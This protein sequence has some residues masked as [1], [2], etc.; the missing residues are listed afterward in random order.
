MGDITWGHVEI[1]GDNGNAYYIDSTDG[2]KGKHVKT[3]K[4]VHFKQHSLL[5]I[6]SQ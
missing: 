1:W 6:I 3:Y 2:L 5:S 4:F